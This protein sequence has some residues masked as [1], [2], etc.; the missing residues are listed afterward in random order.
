MVNQFF[1]SHFNFEN[2]LMDESMRRIFT[3]LRLPK[4]SQEIDRII[5]AFSD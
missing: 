5:R 1:F 4:E 2:D 3:K